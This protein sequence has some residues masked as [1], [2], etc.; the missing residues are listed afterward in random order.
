M[1]ILFKRAIGYAVLGS[2][3]YALSGVLVKLV[4][5][6]VPLP[7]VLFFRFFIGLLILSPWF[8]LDKRLVYVNSVKQL[9]FRVIS[10]LIS[11]ICVYYA[12]RYISVADALLLAN[13]NNLFIPLI[14]WMLLGIR[15]PIFLWIFVLFGFLGV[16]LVL[17]PD[18]SLFNGA[19]I[20]GLI[21]GLFSALAIV[22]VRQ[23]TKVT[24]PQQIIFFFFL[25]G[26][27]ASLFFLPFVTFK[28]TAKILIL[29]ILNGILSGIYQFS[30]VLSF[31]YA[32]ARIIGPVYFLIV[33]W[34]AAFDWLIWKHAPDFR[35]ISG[36]LLVIGSSIALIVLRERVLN[37]KS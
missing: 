35:M 3:V 37:K 4:G 36:S 24:T 27:V 23:L 19:A 20:I 32:P 21:G 8:F 12:I 17:H 18:R 25:T 11:I 22:Q 6:E 16:A 30:L 2:W 9:V 34:G 5:V 33:I 15:T 14:V 29:L 10:G 26:A 13:T 1:D 31:K 28:L 7:I